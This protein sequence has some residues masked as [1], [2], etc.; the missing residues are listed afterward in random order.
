MRVSMLIREQVHECVV[1]ACASH[2]FKKA[3]TLESI[4][5]HT[6]CRGNHINIVRLLT[7]EG[8]NVDADN[9]DMETPLFI[10]LDQGHLDIAKLLLGKFANTNLPDKKGDTP[11]IIAAVNLLHP[12]VHSDDQYIWYKQC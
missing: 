6:H 8:A 5:V 10:A 12:C 7:I 4:Y 2:I 11:L 1:Y 3:Y 9:N